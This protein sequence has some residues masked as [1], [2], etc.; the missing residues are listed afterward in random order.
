[1]FTS[2]LDNTSWTMS[3]ESLFLC[4]GVSLILG[5]II[6]FIYMSNGTYS[7]NFAMTLVLLPVLVQLVI[8]MVN[9]NVGTSV[10]VLGTFSLIRFRSAPGSS[11]EIISIFFAM[12]IGLATGMGQ[13]V[14][15]VGITI[16]IGIVLFVLS[17]THFGENRSKQR[18]LKVTI[19]ENLDYAKIFDDLFAE[20]TKKVSLEK[21]KT[22]NLGSMYEL[23]YEIELKEG[24]KEKEF[25]DAI[26]CRNGNLTIICGRIQSIKEEL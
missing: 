4:T 20:Y 6:A 23:Q 21:V 14:F 3:L 7:K 16:I 8:T 15:A 9:G 11:K 26:R 24:G 13:L 10:A 22:T 18:E 17:T 1:M 2:V 5:F 19:P 25:I 12:V